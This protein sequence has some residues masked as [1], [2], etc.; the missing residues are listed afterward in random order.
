MIPTRL[1]KFALIALALAVVGH[2]AAALGQGIRQVTV[3]AIPSH[4]NAPCPAHLRFVARVG[5]EKAPMLV[6]YE[7]TRSDRGK[8]A[9]RVVKV[10][11]P[12]A[13]ELTL[14]EKWQPGSKGERLEVWERIRVRSGTADVSAQSPSVSVVCR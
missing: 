3:I 4:W 6:N 1:V 11:D 10:T 13:R 8:S 12:S 14:V 5:I 2:S 7:W 9:A